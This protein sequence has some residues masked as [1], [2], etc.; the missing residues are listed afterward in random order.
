[1]ARSVWV[2]RVGGDDGELRPWHYIY[3]YSIA[4]RLVMR[5][6]YDAEKQRSA[7]LAKAGTTQQ[8]TGSTFEPDLDPF[9]QYVL[10]MSRPCPDIRVS[11]LLVV[12][13][14]A[15]LSNWRLEN[16]QSIHV[17]L[18]ARAY[19]CRACVVRNPTYALPTTHVCSGVPF[20]LPEHTCLVRNPFY[21]KR[22]E[23]RLTIIA[24]ELSPI[25]N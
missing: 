23:L 7:M 1:M 24:P 4:S 16:G 14:A 3:V 10:K 13:S 15:S 21:Y 11:K 22:R 17:L 19:M 5:V 9:L 8:T 25:H 20:A 6:R 2:V 18:E 12:F